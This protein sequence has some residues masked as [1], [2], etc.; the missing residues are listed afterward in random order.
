ME[1]KTTLILGP[2][3]AGKST[4]VNALVPNARA[5]TGEISQALN[6]GKHTTTSTSLYW[7]GSRPDL[8]ALA[9]PGT[10]IIDSPGFQE[11]GLQHIPQNQLA[12]CMPDLKQHVPNCKFSIDLLATEV[13]PRRHRIYAQL[14]EELGQQRWS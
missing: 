1:G 10:A 11:F 14:F 3:G 2:S 6:S 4:L 9:M 5:L 7:V 13:S 8:S 12:A